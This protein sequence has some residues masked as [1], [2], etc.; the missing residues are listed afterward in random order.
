MLLVNFL[1]REQWIGQAGLVNAKA[2]PAPPLFR[3][4]DLNRDWKAVAA[5]GLPIPA[6]VYF[7]CLETGAARAMRKLIIAR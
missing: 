7:A 5:D 1:H 2:P 3:H 6:G 4:L